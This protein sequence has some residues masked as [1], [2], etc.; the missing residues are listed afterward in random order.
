MTVLEL[1]KELNRYSP[2]D[3]VRVWTF[4]GNGVIDGTIAKTLARNNCVI[5]SVEGEKV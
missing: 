3:E 1:V 5:I 4:Y 2:D